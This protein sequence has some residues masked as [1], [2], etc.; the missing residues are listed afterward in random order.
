MRYI[1]KKTNSVGTNI[2]AALAKQQHVGHGLA[3]WFAITSDSIRSWVSAINRTDPVVLNRLTINPS[4]MAV[5]H[6]ANP[7]IH[8]AWICPLVLLY[9]KDTIIK[10]IIMPNK[11]VSMH[12]I[13]TK[14][15]LFL[16]A[17]KIPINPTKN[18]VIGKS[19][20]WL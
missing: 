16:Y 4:P 10:P 2:V 15:F 3:C 9:N 14:R 5:S 12:I 13:K 19:R 1:R 7:K 18:K 8:N 11:I 20:I 6:A 17:K